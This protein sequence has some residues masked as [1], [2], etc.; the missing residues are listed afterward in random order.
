MNVLLLPKRDVFGDGADCVQDPFEAMCCAR[1]LEQ[2][3]WEKESAR[4]TC[5]AAKEGSVRTSCSTSKN[6]CG[7]KG[8]RAFAAATKLVTLAALAAGK[9]RLSMCLTECGTRPLMSL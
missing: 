1:G 7:C 2:Q 9:S 3:A 5:R 6:S 8:K 4:G